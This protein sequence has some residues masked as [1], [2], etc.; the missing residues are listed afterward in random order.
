MERLPVGE[1][2]DRAAALLDDA[3]GPGRVA[4]DEA[5][6]GFLALRFRVEPRGGRLELTGEL[7]S[8]E[9]P[10]TLLGRPTSCVGRER[11]LGVLEAT[12]D[13]VITE[14]V[15]RAAL[16]TGPSGAG[17]SRVRHELAA[18][19]R[20]RRLA[21]FLARA[22]A[23]RS[24]SPLDLLAGLVRAGAGV[25]ASDAPEAARAKLVA[26]VH[27]RLAGADRA[28]VAEFL[29]EIIGAPFPDE[30]SPRLR[31]ARD[32]GRV[33]G[34]HMQRAFVSWLGAECRVQPV[35]LILEDL[36]WGDAQTVRFLDAA[37]RDLAKLPL[38]VLALARPEVHERFPGLWRGRGLSELPLAALPP[39]ACERLVREVLGHLD[40]RAVERIVRHADG[41]ALFLEELIRAASHGDLET[42][43]VSVLAMVQARLEALDARD[44]RV[45]RAA[46]VFGESFTRDGAAALVGEPLA[47]E[48]DDILERLVDAEIIVRRAEAELAFRHALVREA[49]YAMLTDE[50][51]RLG[52]GLAAAWLTA[53]GEDDAL[54]LAQHHDR[55][56]DTASAIGSYAR[57]ARQAFE[58]NDFDAA[59][60]RAQRAI[61]LGAAEVVLGE[62]HAVRGKA[63]AAL[64]RWVEAE[65]ALAAALECPSPAAE[66]R[67][68]MLRDT[69]YVATF[70]QT[71][72]SLRRAG[73]EVMA[74]AR[75]AGR[76]DL[77]AE[78]NAALATADHADGRCD[79]AVARYRESASKVERASC[80]VGL[81]G[82]MLYHSGRH[83]E[84]EQV[85]KRMLAHADEIRDHATAVILESGVGLV[86]AAQ[87]RYE[88]A[89]EAFAASRAEAE[90]CGLL[91]LAARSVSV[92]AGHRIDLLD[93][94]GA[95][96]LAREA[97]ELGGKLE[98]ATPR[99]SSSIDLA[100]IAIRRGDPAEALRITDS[101]AGPVKN[102][103]GFHGWLWRERVGVLLAQVDLARGDLDGALRRAD[104]SIEECRRRGRTKYRAIAQMVRARALAG[105][106]RTDDGVREMLELLDETMAASPDPAIHLQISL[107]LLGIS[108]E[109]RARSAAVA[110]A[111]RIE[112]AL[113]AADRPAFRAAAGS[114]LT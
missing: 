109:E 9:Q 99:I 85:M 26:V 36:Q 97:V 106:G 107:G 10:R 64:G 48:I 46:S 53:H 101:I 77:E 94:A 87:G 38:F 43:P 90:T 19:R 41:N 31:A 35:L 1:V 86:L 13:E 88:E 14:G 29:G 78:A 102:G 92:S 34:A 57:A 114:M 95:E 65:T 79:E 20:D 52:H 49:A 55:A 96:A 22:E 21:I 28:D 82:I 60:V 7:E 17:K 67:M 39:R 66:R 3:P 73:L 4:I 47:R 58:K 5:S 6:A 104:A 80:V 75:A 8:G 12:L 33:M 112:A 84:G 103:I 30:A 56:G 83:A 62:A 71:S 54:L 63:L 59:L 18:R 93:L 37:L 76:T 15:A 32:D 40:A 81:A 61:D 16:V 2:I 105:L 44:R 110:S 68:E 98:F 113:P 24:G 108:R 91:T 23:L 89:R 11:E 74:L 45:L 111:T 27:R 70:R 25:A 100:M 69:Y 51:R 72:A 50:D 42:L